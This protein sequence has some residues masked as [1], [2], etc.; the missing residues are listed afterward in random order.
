MGGEQQHAHAHAPPPPL[1]PPPRLLEMN[2][3]PQQEETLG[4]QK[5]VVDYHLPIELQSAPPR[6]CQGERRERR[7]YSP[8]E[9]H[10]CPLLLS[11]SLKALR[12][13]C[14]Q[15]LQQQRQQ[16]LW[17]QL[18]LGQQRTLEV[19]RRKEY[20]AAVPPPLSRDAA[21]GYVLSNSP[22][23]LFQMRR[24]RE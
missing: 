4:E 17:L 3:E 9:V 2:P 24:R 22:E 6:L 16:L 7:V 21:A 11:R 23:L 20:P 5:E 13:K 19:A 12:K 15:G 1:P 14:G 18:T 10:R 8:E